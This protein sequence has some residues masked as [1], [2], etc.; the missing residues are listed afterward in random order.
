[1]NL[2]LP[3]L[4]RLGQQEPALRFLVIGAHAVFSHGHTRF[5]QDVD[6][7]VRQADRLLWIERILKAG[8][9]PFAEAQ[10]FAQFE[11][12]QGDPFDLMFV[13]DQTFEKLWAGRVEKTFKETPAYV[14]SVDDLIILKLHALKQKLPHRTSK[15]MEDVEM[16]IRRNNLDLN[17]SHYQE[18]F[19]KYGSR[20]I[21]ETMQR[22]LKY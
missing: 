10:A 15:D 18:L 8:F 20:D 21:Y 17:S 9:K 11:Q 19:L 13:N 14:P 4:I 1:V 22:I 5:T 6:F 16:M 12:E 2:Y 3:D 7:L